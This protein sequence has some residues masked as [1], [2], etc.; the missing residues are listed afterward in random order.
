MVRRDFLSTWARRLAVGMVLLAGAPGAGAAVAPAPT[1]PDV[2]VKELYQ[3]WLSTARAQREALARD[4]RKL[5]ALTDEVSGPYIDYQRLGRLVLGKHWRAASPEQRER[6]IREFRAHLVRTYATAM[7]DYIDADFEF[8][9]VKYRPGDRQVIVYTVTRPK[10][11]RPSIPINYVLYFNGERWQAMD[12]IV[13]G[14][15][16]VTTLRSI[17]RSEVQRKS[18]DGV[19][20]ELAEKNRKALQ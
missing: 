18:L 5:Y 20:A 7:F 2:L 16:V 10:D 17:V 4:K 13:E 8:K 19:I 3:K 14:V 9:P 1:A 15:S 6:F 11:G 12:V